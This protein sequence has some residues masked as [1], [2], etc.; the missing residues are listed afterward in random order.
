MYNVEMLEKA[1]QFAFR[2]HESQRRKS[3]NIP[4][5]FHLADVTTRLAFYL[6]NVDDKIK[7]KILIAGMLHDVIEDCN[8]SHEEIAEYFSKEI[9]DIVLECS[10]EHGHESK[11]QKYEFLK[12]FENKSDESLIIKIA[13]RVS[14][15]TDY[16]KTVGKAQYASTYALQASPLYLEWIKRKNN[17][18]M[19]DFPL[20]KSIFNFY[21]VI[22]DIK[23]MEDIISKVYNIAFFYRDKD[24]LFASDEVVKPLV[25]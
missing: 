24:I 13:D 21:Y 12:S 19:G 15:V 23:Y 10:R 20:S 16:Y 2:A 5:F 14:N 11:L 4:Y 6:Q 9:A 1:T 25:T 18:M 8:Y 22:D 7:Y 3:T 17:F